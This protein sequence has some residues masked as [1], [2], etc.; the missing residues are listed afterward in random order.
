LS[1]LTTLPSEL[2]KFQ[3]LS[4]TESQTK[5]GLCTYVSLLYFFLPDFLLSSSTSFCISLNEPR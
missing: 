3:F 4:Q 5:C 1:L 2:R